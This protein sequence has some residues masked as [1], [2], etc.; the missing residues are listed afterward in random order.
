M[1]NYEHCT[2]QLEWSMVNEEQEHMQAKRVDNIVSVR[3]VKE[4]SLMYKDRSIRS[5]E[6]G[7]HLFKEFLGELDREYFV[8]M[9][10]DVK[11]EPT[12]I[13]VCHIRSLNSSVVH[14]REVMKTAILP[15]A[16][17]IKRVTRLGLVAASRMYLASRKCMFRQLKM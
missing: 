15:S 2:K 8:V 13:N 3:L 9:C 4:R 1:K 7:Y 12:A 16:C 11:N 10:L 17:S 14:P 6:D 5:P